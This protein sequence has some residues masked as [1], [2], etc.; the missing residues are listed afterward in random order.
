MRNLRPEL[1]SDSEDR[2]AYVLERPQLEY[3]LETITSRNQTQDFELFC[4]RLCEKVI[5]PNLRPQT[6]PEG[7]GDAKTDSETYSVADEVSR[8]FVGEPNSGRERWAFAFSAK[9]K[10]AAENS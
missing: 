6:G 7:G 2:S 10:M 3:Q 8:T 9:A 5:C 1:Y 4:R